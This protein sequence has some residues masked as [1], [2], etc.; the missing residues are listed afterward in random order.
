[1]KTMLKTVVLPLLILCAIAFYAIPASALLQNGTS[2]EM[3]DPPLSLDGTWIILDE[4][5]SP[6]DFFTGEYTW[7]SASSVLFTITDLYVVTDYFEV[8][9]NNVFVA[10]TPVLPDWD[11]YTTNPFDSAV[12]TGDPDV[13]LA[14]GRFSSA[15]ILFAPGSHS[16]TISDVHIPKLCLECSSP[17]PD[18]T[19]AFKAESVPE[20]ATFFLL[21]AGIIG[22][23]TLRKRLVRKIA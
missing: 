20:P 9:D 4:Y 2:T 14:D 10:S 6:G 12:W 23:V 11:T 5:M 7:D 3:G 22:I 16:I 18:G 17:F 13:A 8:Y 1:M 15:A 21:G 19:V